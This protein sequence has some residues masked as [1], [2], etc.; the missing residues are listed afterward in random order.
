MRGRGPAVQGRPR[1]GT[2]LVKQMIV[3]EES[4]DEGGIVSYKLPSKKRKK[5]AEHSLDSAVSANKR[6]TKKH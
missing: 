5:T 1:K 4:E 3:G 2:R 6:A